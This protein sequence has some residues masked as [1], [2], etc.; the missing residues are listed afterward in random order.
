MHQP[1]Q[2]KA[3]KPKI[4]VKTRKNLSDFRA[5][6]PMLIEKKNFIIKTADS[7]EELRQALRLRHD[8]FLEELLK[9]KKRTGMDID[10]FDRLCDHLLILDKKDGKLIGTYRM[11]SSLHT[12]RWYS[13][14]EFHM[15]QIK[16]LPGNKLELGRACVHKDHRNG[17][18]I[19]LLWEGINAYIE[20]SD[21]KYLFGCSSIKTMDREEIKAIYYYLKHHG[22][23]E[24]GSLVRPRS[25]FRVPGFRRHVHKFPIPHADAGTIEKGKI[26]S[27]LVSY[28]K[29]GAKI[30]G[31]PA[32]DKSFKCIDF[33][34]LLDVDNIKQSYTRKSRSTGVE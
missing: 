10:R 9:R 1:S 14:T 8:V 6:I 34:T 17:V 15:K 16:L 24:E 2:K 31:T 18:T 5:H 26:P 12:K 20:A 19:A 22:H 4:Q 28:L 32:L 3:S 33:L 7:L 21:T 25:K 27:L 23:L 30:C 29:A 13:A 11:Q